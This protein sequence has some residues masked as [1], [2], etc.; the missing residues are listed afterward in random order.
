VD[1]PASMEE[2]G[3]DQES[4]EP[5]K[6]DEEQDFAALIDFHPYRDRFEANHRIP[7]EP[8]S[9][10]SILAELGAMA[11]E[12]D[13]MG[14]AGRVSGS[15]YHGGHDHYQFLTEAYGLFAHANVLQRDMYPSA[16]KLEGEIVA[17]TASLLHGE[18]VAQHHQG[19][20]VCGVVTF[21]GTESLINP[22]LVYR[23]RGRIE[24]GITAPEVIIPIT[25]HVALQKA[26]HMLGITLLQAPVGDDWRADVDWMRDHVTENTVAI[27]GSA[28]N[29]PHGLIDPIE[30]MS[31][32]ALEHDLG[33]HVDG[34]MGG[35][36]LPWAER[37]GYP[38]PMFDFRLPGVT[39]ISAD[40]HKFGYALKGTSVLLYRNSTLR[41][42][43]Y[44]SYPDWP[45]G[46][47]MSPGL[48]GS[49]SGGIVAAA[50][51]AMLSLGEQG[52]ME[53]AER[54][55]ETAATILTGVAEIPEL[56]IFGDPTFII[57]FRG[58]GVD[59]YH[60]NDLLISKGW[61]LNA[62]QLPPGLHFCVTR[63]NTADGVAEAF[64]AD[65]HEAVAYAKTPGLGP[66][67]S[68]ALYGLGGSPEGNEALDM[69]FAAA[70]DAMYD[71]VP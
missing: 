62:L 30:E 67:R 39:S 1:N 22:M 64:L 13:R 53:I 57:A 71:V 15:I 54:I 66:A 51:A 50:W 63:P 65:L 17:M 8:R 38:I 44:F 23:E 46:I 70:L 33:L 48:S 11:T 16:T 35:F 43:Q 42:Y 18:A 36:I 45:G 25:A 61:R 41:R 58:R 5:Q 34:C 49:R 31:A 69:L 14:N 60:V 10:E 29:Y 2:H 59:I 40:T 32:L 47:Y 6:S 3:V 56:E 21:G 28:G 26:A 27:V 20:E 37:L 19:E 7:A 68:G 12:E 55:F 9:R 52:Y 4:P 24:K